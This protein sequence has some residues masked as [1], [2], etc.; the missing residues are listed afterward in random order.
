MTELFRQMSEHDF[1]PDY[2]LNDYGERELV[3]S[4]TWQ[5]SEGQN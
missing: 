3:S 1:T 4:Y 2:K 5:K